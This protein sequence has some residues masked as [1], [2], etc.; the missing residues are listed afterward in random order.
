MKDET[1]QKVADNALM[2]AQNPD[3][4]FEASVLISDCVYVIR[5]LLQQRAELLEALKA[6]ARLREI[7]QWLGAIERTRRQGRTGIA[8]DDDECAKEW[9]KLRKERDPLLML[10]D[11]AITRAAAQ[12]QLDKEKQ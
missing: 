9:Q 3:A 10:I 8:V 6:S 7:D 12:I 11:A 1:A 4:S 2:Y 5:E